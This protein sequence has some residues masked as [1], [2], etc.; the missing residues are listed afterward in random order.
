MNYIILS[1]KISDDIETKYKSEVSKYNYTGTLDSYIINLLSFEGAYKLFNRYS[2]RNEYQLIGK[3]CCLYMEE[4]RNYN[5]CFYAKHFS[6]FRTDDEYLSKL[7]QTIDLP[8]AWSVVPFFESFDLPVYD[9]V[10][11]DCIINNLKPSY[12]EFSNFKNDLKTWDV[13]NTKLREYEEKKELDSEV[14]ITNVVLENNIFMLTLNDLPEHYKVEEMVSI[15]IEGNKYFEKLGIISKIEKATKTLEIPCE[16]YTF[17]KAYNQNNIGRFLKV[18]TI[19]FGAKAR[20]NR[21]N[22]ALKRLYQNESANENLMDILYGDFNWDESKENTLTTNDT[23]GLFG[24]NIYQKEAYVGAINSK[25]FFM[26]QGPPGTGKTTIITELVKHAVANEQKVLVTSET[27]IAVDNVLERVNSAKNVVPV[28]LGNI[29][30]VSDSC[31]QYLPEIISDSIL[32]DVKS[33]N[34]FFNENGVNKQALIHDCNITFIKTETELRNKINNQKEQIH[35]NSDYK[36]L[37]EK[38]TKFEELVLT[39]NELYN[40]IFDD[41]QQYFILKKRLETLETEKAK[42]EE[43][44]S[45]VD[46]SVMSAGL[47]CDTNSN[48]QQKAVLNNSLFLCSKEI[49]TVKNAISCNKYEIV[50]ASYKRKMRRFEKAKEEM[51]LLFPSAYSIMA[52]VHQVKESLELITRLENDI[53]YLKIKHETDLNEIEKDCA[54]KN[55]LWDISKDIRAEWLSVIDTPEVKEEIEQIYISRTNVVFAT[56]TG[57]SSEHNGHFAETDY[58]YVIVDEAAKCN[59]LDLLIPI[60]MGKKIV[61]VGD[62]KQLYPMLDT[63]LIKDELTTEQKEELKTNILFKRLFEEKVPD[64]FKSTLRNQYRM[65]KNISQFVSDTFYNSKLICEKEVEKSD[66]MVW[67]DCEDSEEIYKDPS[68]QNPK[69]AGVIISLLTKLDKILKPNT[70]VGVICTYR[71]QANYVR[72]L[73]SNNYWNNIDV[74]CD[75]VD[76]F[77][78]KEKH[79]IIFN[80]VLSKKILPFIK[81]EN[82]VN[83]AVSRAQDQ[84]F[85]VGSTKL[86]KTSDSGVLR[87]LF[88]YIKAHGELYGSKYVR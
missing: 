48:E 34:S 44:I 9:A 7:A 59:T 82:R 77:Q 83:V 16:N 64:G 71:A 33:K 15:L 24:S 4:A 10:S 69:E 14:A 1:K 60:T 26:I 78:G 58:D 39:L 55:E 19:D 84:L 52:K 35:V 21:Q 56:C 42:I 18:R 8:G 3:H 63:D 57:I 80:T 28:R 51:M 30:R 75:T 74:E 25:D 36:M 45:L 37:Y 11:V 2:N 12:M 88:E 87:K 5:N 79:T 6:F 46:N 23:T 17:I 76:A 40:Q 73:I 49:D 47:Q 61:L 29:E 85:V 31:K 86:I 72:K 27:N 81:D 50:V 22:K 43:R 66:S 67:I 38:I 41:E 53:E 68:Y 13:Y 20:L 54:R 70:S 62:H 65:E 32:Y